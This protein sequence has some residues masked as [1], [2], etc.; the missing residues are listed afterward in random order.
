[1]T[2]ILKPIGMLCEFDFPTT[3]ASSQAEL[4]DQGPSVTLLQSGP[5]RLEAVAWQGL[6]ANRG[7]PDLIW[8][9]PSVS[10][11]PVILEAAEMLFPAEGRGR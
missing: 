5:C 11:Q 1:L 9:L 4:Q 6:R 8:A 2:D 3:T 10:E 7:T